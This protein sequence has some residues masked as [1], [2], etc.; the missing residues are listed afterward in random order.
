MVVIPACLVGRHFAVARNQF[1]LTTLGKLIFNQN[2]PPSFP[3]YLNDLKIYNSEEK[4][5]NERL[6][7]LDQIEKKWKNYRSQGG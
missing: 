1:L 7:E 5:G 3:F 4:E 6:V 2:L